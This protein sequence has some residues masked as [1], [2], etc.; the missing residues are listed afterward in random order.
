MPL[1]GSECHSGSQSEQGDSILVG[2]QSRI[3]NDLQVGR[4][5]KVLDKL[6][7]VVDLAYPLV[8]EVDP[9]RIRIRAAPVEADAEKVA[10]GLVL[11]S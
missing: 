3:H 4:D 7:P 11:V 10:A 9:E 2:V 8:V 1:L 5:L 6:D